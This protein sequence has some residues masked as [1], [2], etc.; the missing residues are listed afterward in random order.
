MIQ[1]EHFY[2]QKRFSDWNEISNVGNQCRNAFKSGRLRNVVREVSYVQELNQIFGVKY[3]PN[4]VHYVMGFVK[5][6]R[7]V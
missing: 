4:A 1:V 5:N 6:H 3:L 2:A 7:L